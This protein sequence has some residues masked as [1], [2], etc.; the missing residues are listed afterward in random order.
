MPVDEST[1]LYGDASVKFENST[2]LVQL[3]LMKSL[4]SYDESVRLT[5][6]ARTAK[7]A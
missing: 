2:Q 6:A 1:N 4:R 5:T 3:G 7:S